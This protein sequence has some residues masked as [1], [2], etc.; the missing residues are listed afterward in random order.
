M[1]RIRVKPSHVTIRI[2]GEAKQRY[3]SA[4]QAL[5]IIRVAVVEDGQGIEG[6]MKTQ[7]AL[8]DCVRRA[9]EELEAAVRDLAL[10]PIAF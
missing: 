7:Q 4:I 3:S 5:H 2:D 10:A 8:I 1:I 6:T 9:R